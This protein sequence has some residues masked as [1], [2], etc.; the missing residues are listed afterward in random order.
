VPPLARLVVARLAHFVFAQLALHLLD[1]VLIPQIDLPFAIMLSSRDAFNN[2]PDRIEHDVTNKLQKSNSPGRRE[3]L[4]STVA[5][6][7]AT[8]GPLRADPL[9]CLMI[10]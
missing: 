10:W 2:R 1:K 5:T 9:N 6:F 4:C 3:S 7:V 8:V